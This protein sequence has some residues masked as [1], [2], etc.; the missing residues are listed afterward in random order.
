LQLRQKQKKEYYGRRNI[1][2][3]RG[4]SVFKGDNRKKRFI[5]MNESIYWIVNKNICI[6]TFILL[7]IL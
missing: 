5:G 6:Q 7:N 2:K 4:V 3:Y 1:K